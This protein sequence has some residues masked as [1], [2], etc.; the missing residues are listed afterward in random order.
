MNYERFVSR[1][2]PKEIKSTRTKKLKNGNSLKIK[3]IKE[4]SFLV[5]L[6]DGWYVDILYPQLIFE[7]DKNNEL[8]KKSRLNPLGFLLSGVSLIAF[9]FFN[10]VYRLIE[11]LEF[12]IVGSLLILVTQLIFIPFSRNKISSIIDDLMK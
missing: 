6:K 5:S 11:I 9:C 4:K 1:I 7:F 8:K 3:M 10:D 2:S 12:A